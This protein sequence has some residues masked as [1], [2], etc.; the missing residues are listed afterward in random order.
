[1]LDRNQV[2]QWLPWAP[3]SPWAPAAPRKRIVAQW[4]CNSPSCQVRIQTQE[5]LFLRGHRSAVPEMLL[6]PWKCNESWWSSRD[7]KNK[8]PPKTLQRTPADLICFWVCVAR[9]GQVRLSRAIKYKNRYR[10]IWIY[11]YIYIHIHI[12]ST[13][14][15]IYIYI[16]DPSTGR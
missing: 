16:H 4:T 9:C 12:L 5:D 11:I 2:G 7:S 6:W 14:I 10:D 13:H 8:E 15:Y 1:M 3:F